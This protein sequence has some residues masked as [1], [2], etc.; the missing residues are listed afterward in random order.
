MDGL[1]SS[2]IGN[3]IAIGSNAH[4]WSYNTSVLLK[5]RSIHE[6]EGV[7]N[8]ISCGMQSVCGG[9]FPFGELSI[10]TSG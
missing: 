1:E 9:N 4:D 7:T 3:T 8:H 5:L 10:P 6:G 2:R